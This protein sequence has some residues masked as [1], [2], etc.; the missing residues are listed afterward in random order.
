MTVLEM[1][2]QLIDLRSQMEALIN[3]GETEER[4]LTDEEAT[5]LAEIRSKIE[6]I[7]ND[8]KLAE[9]ENRKLADN[10]NKI[11]NKS[12]SKMKN[13]KLVD[14]VNG[15]VNQNLTDEQRA[16]VNGNKISYRALQATAETGGE[17]LVPEDKGNLFVAIRNASV[18]SKLG[19]HWITNA[20]GDISLPRYNGST[21]GFKGES[22][23][24]DNGEGEFDEKTL[25]PKRI[26][27]YIDISKQLLAQS[28]EDVEAILIADLAA[29]VSEHLDKQ[30]FSSDAGDDNKPE[31]LFAGASAVTAADVDYDTVLG[32]ELAI[33]EKNGQNFM[34]IANPRV[35]YALK[36]TQVASGLQMVYNAGE[37]DGYKTVVSNSVEGIAAIDPKD[38]YCAVWQGA[39]IT[40]DTVTRAIYN[41]VRIVVNMLVDVELAGGERIAAISVTE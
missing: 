39:E 19:A 5:N 40:V 41:E 8:I 11:E 21:V 31:G 26:T 9:E 34:F 13:V 12:I 28:A 27:G 24:A 30:V 4:Q 20:T 22:I 37:I 16:Y 17:E 38:L 15:I 33:E 29:A 14:L 23:A 25:K 36:G 7:E 1:K 6:N 18:L 3:A 32:L 35:K 10:K 2:E